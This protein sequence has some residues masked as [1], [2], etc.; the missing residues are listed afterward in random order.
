MLE[1]LV[2]QGF[3]KLEIPPSIG[4]I[5]TLKLIQL[6]YC[7]SSIE[8]SAIKIQQEQQSYG[9]YELQVQIIS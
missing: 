9:N 2:L 7:G 4:D 5:S 1:Q 8:T 6:K 3:T